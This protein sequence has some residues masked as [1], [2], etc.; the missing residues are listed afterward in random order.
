[1][2]VLRSFKSLCPSIPKLCLLGLQIPAPSSSVFTSPISMKLF[3]LSS[4]ACS[5]AGI[6][7]VATA[8][9]LG[10]LPLPSDSGHDALTYLVP[11]LPANSDSATPNF[12]YDELLELQKHFWGKFQYPNNIK[13]AESINSSVFSENVRTSTIPLRF[14]QPEYDSLCLIRSQLIPPTGPGTCV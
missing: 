7:A 9:P 10:T 14:N 12:S 5:L 3:S 8:N 1:V 2:S 11:R 13:E 4:L 6:A